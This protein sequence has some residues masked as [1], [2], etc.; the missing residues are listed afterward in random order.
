LL[1]IDR[2]IR[3]AVLELHGVAPAEGARAGP[4]LPFEVL[5]APVLA[6]RAIA[7]LVR[8]RHL[9][10]LEGVAPEVEAQHRRADPLESAGQDLQRL[11]RLEARDDRGRRPEHADRVARRAGARR[12]RVL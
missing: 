6:A 10:L 2:R 1:E 5:E 8:P 11:G 3:A 12:R 7:A 9:E 4:E